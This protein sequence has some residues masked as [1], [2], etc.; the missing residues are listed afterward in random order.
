VAHAFA[1]RVVY[2][3]SLY[4]TGG[5]L[6]DS[7]CAWARANVERYLAANPVRGALTTHEHEDHVGNHASLAGCEVYAP[8][9][10]VQILD[11]GAPRLPFYRWLAWGPHDRAPRVAQPLPRDAVTVDGRRFLVVPTPGHSAEHVAYLDEAEAAAFTG[12]AWFGKLRAVRAKEDVPQQMR[13]VRRLAELDP[14]VVYPTH[15]PLLERPRARMLEVA[16]HFD[17][18]AEKARR[19]EERGLSPRRIRRELLGP[20]PGIYWYSSGAFSA[21]NLIRSLLHGGASP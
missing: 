11:D 19:L 14:A 9:R 1:G 6:V 3:T 21:E 13:S 2:W 16:D 5:V 10:A 18:L 8:A 15:G 12:D 17:R 20:E 4:R 7:G